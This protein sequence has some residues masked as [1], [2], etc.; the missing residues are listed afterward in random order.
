MSGWFG[1]A[2]LS[3]SVGVEKKVVCYSGA[4]DREQVMLV[5]GSSGVGKT[6]LLRVLARLQ[7]C[8]GGDV[9]LGGRHWSSFAPIEWRTAVCYVAQQPAIFEGTVRDN[10]MRSFQLAAVRKRCTYDSALVEKSMET[11]VLAPAL[12]DQDARLL[13]GGEATR[14]AVLRA[15]LV[16]PTVL[17]LDEPTAALDRV[18]TVGLCSLLTQWLT[19]GPDRGVV[20]ITHDELVVKHLRSPVFLEMNGVRD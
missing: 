11:L 10:L 16:D 15:L 9:W 17:L 4:L 12:L 8:T 18:A 1:F 14:V 19:E 2:G 13:S 20:M 7:H 5:R 3:F 6:T